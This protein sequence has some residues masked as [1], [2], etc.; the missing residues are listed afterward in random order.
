[1]SHCQHHHAAGHDAARFELLFISLFDEGRGYAFPC[2]ADGRVD[3]DG[4]S[5]RVRLNYLYVRKMI[6]RDFSAPAVRP[7]LQ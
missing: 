5:D 4:L 1:M 7:T 6:G 3:L 2:D